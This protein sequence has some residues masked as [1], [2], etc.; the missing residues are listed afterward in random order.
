MGFRNATEAL[1]DA[2]HVACLESR[3]A[4]ARSLAT[5]DGARATVRESQRLRAAAAALRGN[6]W[7]AGRPL[8]LSD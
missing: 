5:R 3:E 4:V 2:S 6:D 1:I 7:I 8:V